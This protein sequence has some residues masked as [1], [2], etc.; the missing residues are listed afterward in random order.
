MK[1]NHRTKTIILTLLV[2]S[3]LLFALS[4][5]SVDIPLPDVFLSLL[6]NTEYSYIVRNIRLPRALGSAFAGAILALC[7]VAFQTAFRNPMADPYLLGTSSGATLAIAIGTVLGITTSFPHSLPFIALLG[8]LGASALT[9]AIGKK[10]PSTLLL[11]GIA[12]STLFSALTSLL[13]FLKRNAL[14]G[15]YFWTMGSMSGMTNRKVAVMALAFVLLVVWMTLERKKMD[16]LLVDDSSA[17]SL[18]LEP[19]RF[20]TVL[21]VTATIATSICVSYCGVIGFLG[22]IAPH[23]ARKIS[24][25]THSRLIPTSALLG[26]LILLVSDTLSRTLTSPSE[27]PVGIIT[28]AMG[29]PLFLILAFGGR[30]H[31]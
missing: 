21:L 20:R 29:C 28:A 27:M 10:H 26:A 2:V 16:I 14:Q 7:G 11:S 6:S 30:R 4:V 24:G 17:L 13:L 3:A 9:L 8:G 25:S 15:I 1:G 22:I 31:E 12:L 23:I 19:E 18:G 5:G